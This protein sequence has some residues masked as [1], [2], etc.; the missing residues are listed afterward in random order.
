MARA[1]QAFSGEGARAQMG[2]GGGGGG[3]G[4]SKGVVSREGLCNPLVYLCTCNICRGCG[5]GV[6]D[7]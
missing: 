6:A 4:G 7:K 3:G 2:G 5:G 1:Q